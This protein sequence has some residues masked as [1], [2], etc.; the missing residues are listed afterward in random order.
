MTAKRHLVASDP[1]YH[2]RLS[3]A[4][5]HTLE[6]QGGPLDERGQARFLAE[7]FA[8]DAIRVRRWDEGAKVP[9]LDVPPL[10]SYRSMIEELPPC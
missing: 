4:S 2:F 8:S 9:G 6:L 1:D 5:V 7:P 3:P 10:A